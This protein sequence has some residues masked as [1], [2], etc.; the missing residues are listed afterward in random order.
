MH[1]F[2][3]LFKAE[4]AAETLVKVLFGGRFSRFVALVLLFMAGS[5]YVL[6]GLLR[7]SYR[8]LKWIITT[9]DMI[10]RSKLKKVIQAGKPFGD[11]TTGVR[12]ENGHWTLVMSIPNFRTEVIMVEFRVEKRTG[13]LRIFALMDQ[14]QPVEL[15]YDWLQRFI[16]RDYPIQMH[17]DYAAY[18]YSQLRMNFL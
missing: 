3:T 8:I 7:I 4:F 10:V 13:K 1:S 16:P 2:W 18:V 14:R 12:F 6:R 9:E 5:W 17:V 15:T 11:T